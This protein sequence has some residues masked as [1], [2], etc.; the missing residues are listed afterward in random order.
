MIFVFVAHSVDSCYWMLWCGW[1]SDQITALT[2][3]CIH[4]PCT[5]SPFRF[6]AQFIS[7]LVLARWNKVRDFFFRQ[8]I[9]M[10][11][12]RRVARISIKPKKK[13]IY[14]PS[15]GS[16]PRN[17]NYILRVNDFV[18]FPLRL[19]YELFTFWA[20]FSHVKPGMSRSHEMK[21]K[22][23]KDHE[24]IKRNFNSTQFVK[25]SFSR[26]TATRK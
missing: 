20:S 21:L 1:C 7:S 19:M 5:N 24:G 3:R 16:R 26:V 22:I 17:N 2:K 10:R 6:V 14:F 9:A 23:T 25:N 12:V 13:F 15:I 4:F 18:Q 8:C 11:L